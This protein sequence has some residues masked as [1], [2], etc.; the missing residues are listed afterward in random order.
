MKIE[1]YLLFVILLFVFISCSLDENVTEPEDQFVLVLDFEVG[2]D[3]AEPS[4]LTYDPTTQSLW[5]VND[6]P[7]NQIYNIG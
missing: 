3:I 6:P 2:L 5:T 7:T 1:K 4:G